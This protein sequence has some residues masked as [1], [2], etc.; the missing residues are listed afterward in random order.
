MNGLPQ[1][2]LTTEPIADILFCPSTREDF[3]NKNSFQSANGTIY[4][5]VNSIP[6]LI[7]NPQL[8]LDHWLI[9]KIELIQY[10][11]NRIEKINKNLMQK[12][13]LT[14]TKLRLENTKSSLLHNQQIL[15]NLLKSLPCENNSEFSL[16][17][18]IPSHQSLSLYFKNIFRDWSWNTQENEISLKMI[19]KI[20]PTS[21]SPDKFLI[22]GS[23]SSRLAVDLHTKFKLNCSIATD[24]NPLLLFIAQNILLGKSIKLYDFPQAPVSLSQVAVENTLKNPYSEKI[25]N[26]QLLFADIQKLPIKS[27]TIDS[28]LTPWLIDIIPLSFSLT[29]QRINRVLKLGGEWLN[30]GPLGFMFSDENLCS[31]FEE[32]QELLSQSGFKIEK[33]HIDQVPYLDCP[34]TSQKRTEQ[35]LCFRAIKVADTT[36]DAFTYLP[37]WLTN[38]NE[39]IPLNELIREA[40]SHSRIQADISHSIDGKKS[41][42]DIIAL[43][44]QHYKI[45]PTESSAALVPFLVKLFESKNRK[46]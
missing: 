41:V 23:G 31:T 21:W 36:E 25:E 37:S 28:V 39:P 2:P 40:Q 9:K 29:A 10:Y 14:P 45:S 11:Q 24:I 34:Y 17:K 46:I 30:Y 16:T 20:L 8:Q 7:E 12:N 43:M 42:N 6:W 3:K 5:L 18:K 1:V 4:P 13:L 22:L 26:F 27:K 44:S 32:I 15:T 33:H 35:V 38:Y 19:E